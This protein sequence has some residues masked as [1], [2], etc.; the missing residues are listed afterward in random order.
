MAKKLSNVS[1][2]TG[3]EGFSR[4]LALRRETCIDKIGIKGD[5]ATTL[6]SDA[7]LVIPGNDYLGVTEREVNVIG[8]GKVKRHTLFIRKAQD[9]VM[10][11]TAQNDQR[12][13]FSDVMKWVYA[14]QHDL[15]VIS[16]N[17]AK[18]VAAVND[19]TKKINGV[20][21]Y[22]Y[23]SMA[24][25]MRGVAFGMLRAGQTLPQNHQLPDWDA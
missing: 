18:F 17:Q 1:F 22:G 3:I 6:Y 20:S 16:A 8:V 2:I 24:G 21:A 23:Q 12:N 19:L 9:Y 14:A 10:P 4:K 7:N 11:T 15:T 25:W 5:G 13:N